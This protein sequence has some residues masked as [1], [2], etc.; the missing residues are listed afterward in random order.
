M[1]KVP[2]ILSINTSDSSGG[3][4]RAAY[5]IHSAVNEFGGNSY[6]LVKNKE[7]N[8]ERILEV[9]Q[10]YHPNYIK[11]SYS[12]IQNKIKNKI[13][14]HCWNKYPNRENVF[15][16]DLRSMSIHGAFQKIDFDI[17]H[18]HWIN[19]RFLNLKE[20]QRIQ[21]PIIWTLHDCWPFTGICHYFYNCQKYIE[22]CGNCP[23]LHSGKENDLSR[24]ILKKKE[25]YY[26]GLNL[27]IVTPSYWLAS[28]ALNSKLFN[29]FPITVI[30]NLID[31]QMFIPKEKRIA[32]QLLNLDPQRTYILFG[33][34]NALQDKNK[35]V[36]ELINAIN[37]YIDSKA[38]NNLDLLI[39]GAENEIGALKAHIPVHY[40][41]IIDDDLK[42]T[43]AY[44]AASVTVVPSRSENLSN[45]IMESLSCGTPV[46]AFN[47]GGNSDLIIH[48]QNGYLA[49]P[50]SS[51]DLAEGILYCI[52]NYKKRHLSV[53]ARQKA[54]TDYSKECI[55][56]KYIELYNSIY[57]SAFL[58]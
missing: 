56:S 30:P 47:V 36:Q 20:L 23:F 42:M 19:L 52:N 15:M 12:F 26:H 34:M 24:Q 31:T 39:F 6:M 45:T 50:Y 21:K 40:L 57:N 5:R 48:C 8:D 25:I 33:A 58:K 49:Q 7:L 27:H 17:L 13:Q 10:Y 51:K 9:G 38:Y 22:S 53:N 55:S 43:N 32:C 46:V 4:A 28:A 35:G 2:K 37:M 41:G 14:H 44:C 16:S 3:A 29:P 18:M 11:C 1:T 54:V